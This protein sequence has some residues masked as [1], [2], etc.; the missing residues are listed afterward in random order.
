[1]R[2]LRSPQEGLSMER[3]AIIGMMDDLKLYG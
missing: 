2:P 3:S 1:M